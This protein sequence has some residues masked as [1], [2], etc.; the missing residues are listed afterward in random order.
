MGVMRGVESV[1]L[2]RFGIRSEGD[3]VRERGVGTGGF[4]VLR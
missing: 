3:K 1:P 2:S 4:Y